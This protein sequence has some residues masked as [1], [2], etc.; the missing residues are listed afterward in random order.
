MPTLNPDAKEFSADYVCMNPAAKD[1]V[2]PIKT[3]RLL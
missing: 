1:F 3:P 2:S